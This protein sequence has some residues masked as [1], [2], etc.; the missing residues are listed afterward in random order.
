MITVNRVGR[1]FDKDDPPEV[2]D[3]EPEEPNAEGR[4]LAILSF[5]IDT[6]GVDG[7][8]EIVREDF[9]RYVAAKKHRFPIYIFDRPERDRVRVTTTIG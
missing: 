2:P 5:L 7:N 6:I 1:Y 4:A 9:L 3:D 8:M